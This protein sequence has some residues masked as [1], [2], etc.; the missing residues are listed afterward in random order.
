MPDGSLV[1]HCAQIVCW[2]LHARPSV[3]A[4]KAWHCDAL[5]PCQQLSLRTC[6]RSFLIGAD[7]ADAPKNLSER[8]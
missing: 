1:G 2:V 6:S 3:E 5:L 4:S 8:H 7:S